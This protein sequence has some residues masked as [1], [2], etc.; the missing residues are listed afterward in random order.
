MSKLSLYLHFNGNCEKAFNH[1]KVV[2][3]AELASITRYGDVPRQDGSP[4]IPEKDLNK[5]ENIGL[6][7]DDGSII[8]GSDM[9]D[10]WGQKNIVGNNFSIYITASSKDE[11]DKFFDGLADGGSITMPMAVAHWGD[12]FGMCTDRFGISWLVN[13]STPK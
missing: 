8:M 2:F 6:L 3:N 7:L 4:A 5:I 11:A 12:Y 9:L 13:Y 10:I 1:Y